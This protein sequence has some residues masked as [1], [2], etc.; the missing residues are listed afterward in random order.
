MSTEV[1][2][3]GGGGTGNSSEV[4]RSGAVVAGELVGN[5]SSGD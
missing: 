4:D 2:G 3:G 5:F 1:G